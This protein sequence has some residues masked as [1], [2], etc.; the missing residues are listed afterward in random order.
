MAKT[1]KNRSSKVMPSYIKKDMTIHALN[2]WY[3]AMFE[4]LGWMIL[5]KDKGYN[6]KIRTYITSVHRLRD[7]LEHKVRHVKESDRADDLRIMHQNVLLLI[8]H[9]EKDFA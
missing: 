8:N 6:D 9:V 5:A 4:K 1:R 3:E 2:K 7:S